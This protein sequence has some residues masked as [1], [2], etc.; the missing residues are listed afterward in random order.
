MTEN[1]N[2]DVVFEIRKVY[3]KDAS[4]ESPQAPQIFV[5]DEQPA[6]DVQMRMDHTRL[7]EENG[8]YE[9]VLTV[10]VTAKSESHTIFLV[11]LQQ[12]GIFEISNVPSDEIDVALEV[13]CPSTLFPYAREAISDM[14]GRGGFPQLLISPVNFEALYRR[15][16]QEQK[17]A[18]QEAEG[19]PTH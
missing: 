13:A 6:I 14:I 11:E 10:T 7:D 5:R 17:Q 18:E 8:I 19:K 16:H 4:F 12:A 3:V 2:K 1:Q 9:S 15:R